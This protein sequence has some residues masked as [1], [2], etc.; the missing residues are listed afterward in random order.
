MAIAIP[1]SEATRHF[2][3]SPGQLLIGGR[4]VDAAE[5]G[6][7]ETIDPGTGEVLT[8]VAHG[9]AE[10]VNRAVAA[11]R[12]ALTG[13]WAKMTPSER[14]RAI[15]RLG[16]LVAENAD[17]LAELDSLDNGKAKAVA[18]A[19][20]V[21][22]AADLFWYMAGWATKLRGSTVR[23]SLP[24]IPGAEFHA[25]TVKEPVGVVGQI[26]PWNFPLLMAAWKLGPA[27]ATG[28]TIVLKPAEQT[29]LSALRLG[30]LALEAGIPDGVLNIVTGFGDAGAALAEH[31]DVDKV[32]FTG[33][34]EVGKLI[35]QAAGR[36]N[37]K[38]VSLELGGKSPNVILDDADVEAAIAG[39]AQGIFFNQGEVCTAASRLYI[40]QNLFDEVVEGVSNAAKAIKV[41]HGMSP[42][43]EMGPLVSSEQFDR[44]TGY[45]KIGAEEG[46]RA[47]TGGSALPGP[48][49]FVQPT[50]LVDATKDHRIMREEI[51]GP[52][53]AATPFASIDD[54]ADQANDSEYGLAAG[55]WTRDISKAHKLAARIKAG[56]VHVNTY[57][58]YDAALPFGGYKQ[59]GWG[60]EMGEEV[61]NAYQETKSVVVAL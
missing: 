27:L 31:N 35:A 8:T 1:V 46:A 36:T 9:T 59:S 11:A 24:Y 10:D 6:T 60:R 51:F 53:V 44:V 12:K 52:V 26:I 39:S 30:E 45:L 50:V 42:D 19:A 34:T 61:L 33:S 49:Y 7:F 3:S 32:A 43:T 23:P 13:T 40:H 54:I 58:I 25:Y 28:C 37:L 21:P 14:G 16:D 48:G 57:H 2:T 41:G 17:E 4:W 22:L 20:D 15:H 38:R 5:G 56:T 55:V 47:V 18:A 29:P